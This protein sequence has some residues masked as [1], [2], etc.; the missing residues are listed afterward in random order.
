MKSAADSSAL[1]PRWTR[2]LR[3][4]VLLAIGA[5]VTFTATM[6]EQ[7]A[8]DHAVIVGSLALL[9]A[10]HLIEWFARKGQ[11]GAPVTLTLSGVAFL[12]MLLQLLLPSATAFPLILAGWALM[13]AVLEFIGATVVPGS[14]QDAPLIGAIGIL[15]ALL[16]IL[17]RLDLVAVIGFFGGYAVIAGVFL[18]IAAFDSKRA[19]DEQL[20]PRVQTSSI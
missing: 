4:G 10:V 16:L 2:L 8:F 14:R 5:L 3:S 7:L 18:G 11:P 1:A 17:V 6:H 15:L 12:A 13:S 19:S 9:G 20:V